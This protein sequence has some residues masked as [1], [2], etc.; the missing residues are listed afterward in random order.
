MRKEPPARYSTPEEF[1]ADIGRYLD[2]LPVAAH[3]G[4]RA[5]RVRKFVARH[6]MAAGISAA[7]LLLAGAGVTAIVRQERIAERRFQQVRKLADSV[8]YELHDGIATL[9]GST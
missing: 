5:Y 8:I 9:P 2:G 3:R 6:R 4:S 1:A 7:A